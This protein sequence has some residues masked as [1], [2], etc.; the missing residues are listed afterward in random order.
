MLNLVAPLHADPIREPNFN[1]LT[2][3]NGGGG[4][5]SR[6]RGGGQVLDTH[7]VFVMDSVLHLAENRAVDVVV[8]LPLAATCISGR[9]F[10]RR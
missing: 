10:R 1:G 4:V 7:N 3:D 2:R 9:F 5:G 6:G 8:G